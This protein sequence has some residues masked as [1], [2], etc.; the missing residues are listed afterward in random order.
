MPDPLGHIMIILSLESPQSVNCSTEKWLNGKYD[1]KNY[2]L[3][4]HR[5]LSKTGAKLSGGGVMLQ[6]CTG[7]NLVN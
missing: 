1:P 2:F 5:P 6:F 4:G 3:N 7:V